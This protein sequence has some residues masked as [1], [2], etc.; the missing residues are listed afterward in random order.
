MNRRRRAR[1]IALEKEAI[2][3]LLRELMPEL[4]RVY[5]VRSLAL[6]GSVARGEAKARSDIDLLVEF[7]DAISPVS[8]LEFVALRNFLSDKLGRRVD[9]VERQT[10]RPTLRDGILRE[11]E[12]I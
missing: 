9:L 12:P 8:L 1:P 11:A 4:Q 2:K 10:L 3:A 7:D 5:R 6:F